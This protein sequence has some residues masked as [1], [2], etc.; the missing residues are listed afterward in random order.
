MSS[1][2][3]DDQN[4]LTPPPAGDA[5]QAEN[6]IRKLIHLI[7]KDIIEITKTDLSQFAPGSLQDHY[8]ITL[9]DYHVEIS[10]SKH[11]QSGNNSYIILFTNIRNLPQSGQKIILAYMHMHDTQFKDIKNVATEQI[12]RIKRKVE[13]KR[14][15]EALLPIDQILDDISVVEITTPAIS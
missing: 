12:E 6:Y 8:R 7:D 11:P 9:N 4:N 2:T 10:H 3:S 5:L 14:L 13:E 1:S 15:K